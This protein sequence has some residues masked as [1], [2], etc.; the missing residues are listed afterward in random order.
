VSPVCSFSVSIVGSLG[1]FNSS[2]SSFETCIFSGI[3]L[4][5]FDGNIGVPLLEISPLY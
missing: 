5:L 1:V 3:F 4:A 2:R